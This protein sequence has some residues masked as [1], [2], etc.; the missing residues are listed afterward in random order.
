M[1]QRKNQPLKIIHYDPAVELLNGSQTTAKKHSRGEVDG[2]VLK[3]LDTNK[4]NSCSVSPLKAAK[5]QKVAQETL[6]HHPI[7][8]SE[9]VASQAKSSS[10]AGSGKY[11]RWSIEMTNVLFY[12]AS[13]NKNQ[14]SLMNNGMKHDGL[15]L[16]AKE[17]KERFPEAAKL[18]KFDLTKINNKIK[19][20]CHNYATVYVKLAE[21]SGCTWDEQRNCLTIRDLGSEV[22]LKSNP[23]FQSVVKQLQK[24]TNVGNLEV[25][26]TYFEP[27]C[28]FVKYIADYIDMS[29]EQ[30]SYTLSNDHLQEL[31]NKQATVSILNEDYEN[32]LE[33]KRDII[34]KLSELAQSKEEEEKAQSIQAL[35]QMVDDNI[36]SVDQ[37][38]KISSNLNDPVKSVGLLFNLGRSNKTYAEK[39]SWI[40]KRYL[41]PYTIQE[42]E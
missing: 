15:K 14:K 7:T 13:Y 42:L 22:N 31:N 29:L 18:G 33:N 6:E 16:I 40:K 32:A 41:D 2:G 12:Y 10:K 20:E 30:T 25:I 11:V 34:S 37:Y 28:M 1:E 24:T 39:V 38:E 3:D 26:Y 5:K 35:D 9:P 8:P 19:L 23:V 21:R 17:L 36:L 4:L 27:N